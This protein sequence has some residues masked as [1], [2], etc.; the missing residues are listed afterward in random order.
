VYVLW[1][2]VCPFVPFLLA[3]VV[4][5]LLRYTDTDYPLVYPNSPC[6][7]KADLNKIIQLAISRN[8]ETLFQLTTNHCVVS[9]EQQVIH[10]IRVGHKSIRP[11]APILTLH[12]SYLL[13]NVQV[14]TTTHCMFYREQLDPAPPKA[15]PTQSI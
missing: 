7:T 5:V 6:I 9:G 1:I 10:N 8:S 13:S 2:V 14:H 15:S 4:Y 3:I 12:W 11:F